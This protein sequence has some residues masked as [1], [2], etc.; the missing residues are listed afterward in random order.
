MFK[1]INSELSPGLQVTL[2][3][4]LTLLISGG[5]IFSLTLGLLTL[6]IGFGYA[7]IVAFVILI[8]WT[9]MLIARGMTVTSKMGYVV[10]ERFGHFRTVLYRGI[11]WI[12]PFF[13]HIRVSNGSLKVQQ[14]PL[15]RDEDTK[16]AMDFTDGV[17]A[18]VAIVASYGVGHPEDIEDERWNLV[19][20]DVRK[21]TYQYAKPEERIDVLLDGALRPRLQSLSSDAAQTQTEAE[22][23]EAAIAVGDA[24]AEI[25]VYLPVKGALVVSDIDLPEDV[26][27]IREEELKGKKDAIAEQARLAAPANAILAVRDALKA[28]GLSRTDDQVVDMLMTQ[29]GLEAIAK[30]GSNVSLY[31]FDVAAILKSLGIAGKGG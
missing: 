29:Q 15:F 14:R 24:L 22:C 13:D 2:L 1:K 9:A 12:N 4:V 18:P 3:D 28:G 16:A 20:E 8:L 31:G 19:T 5:A 25:G 7:L 27:R 17:T 10:V 23:E 30:S 21:Y 6:A 26:I 11:G